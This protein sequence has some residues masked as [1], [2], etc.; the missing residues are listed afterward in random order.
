MSLNPKFLMF[1]AATALFGALWGYFNASLL[2]PAA[3]VSSWLPIIFGA[4]F[5]SFYMLQAL[6]APS[7]KEALTV[8]G[9]QAVII[10]LSSAVSF[11]WGAVA[12]IFFLLAANHGKRDATQGLR[13]DLSNLTHSV[14]PK[15]ITAT[16]IIVSALYTSTA[17]GDNFSLSKPAAVSILS[18]VIRSLSI[19]VSGITP[20]MAVGEALTGF[21]K[22]VLGSQLAA[23]PPAE[24]DEAVKQTTAKTLQSLEAAL[25]TPI[26]SRDSILDAV[27]RSANAGLAQIP[28]SVRPYVLFGFGALVFLTVKGFGFLIIYILYPLVW[29]SHKL[30]VKIGFVKI[31]TEQVPKESVTLN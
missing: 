4:L 26:S 25:G 5:L 2:N 19:F 7:V 12:A 9:A 27:R 30:F 22:N 13:I 6:Y 11:L 15:T 10:V 29:A 21:T 20:N 14:G 23:L 17:F 3:G 18:P 1:S 24:R 8:A 16:A 28:N 31:V